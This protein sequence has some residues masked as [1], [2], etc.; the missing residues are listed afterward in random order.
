M[1]FATRHSSLFTLGIFVTWLF[2]FRIWPSAIPEKRP[3][4]DRFYQTAEIWS[5]DR[6][7]VATGGRGFLVLGE[8]LLDSAFPFRTSLLMRARKTGRHN[9][10]MRQITTKHDIHRLGACLKTLGG[11]AAKDIGRG[12][13]VAGFSLPFLLCALCA[14]L[15]Q[16]SCS[17]GPIRGLTVCSLWLST[18]HVT[19]HPRLV[20]SHAWCLCYF[21]V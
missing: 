14:L 4:I 20:T 3:E 21:V 12:P 13:R 5:I 17:S 19:C 15:R 1:S 11:A 8:V 18:F 10:K 7:E 9:D 6:K 16:I 2:N